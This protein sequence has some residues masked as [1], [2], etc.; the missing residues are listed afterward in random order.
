MTKSEFIA[1]RRRL[2]RDALLLATACLVL[3]ATIVLLLLGTKG[4]DWV[5]N[6][7]H[8]PIAFVL[9]L[10]SGTIL[11][12]AAIGLVKSLHQKH[13]MICPSCGLWLPGQGSLEET[14][15]CKRCQTRIFDGD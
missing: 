3:S 10:G 6:P 8:D 14:G 13:R 7:D 15:R 2:T 1:A 9:I 12:T 11:T 4:R 5:S